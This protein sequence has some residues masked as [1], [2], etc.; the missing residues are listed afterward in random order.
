VEKKKYNECKLWSKEERKIR[1]ICSLQEI[2]SLP[3]RLLHVIRVMA[4]ALFVSFLASIILA[5]LVIP[6]AS[7]VPPRCTFLTA[8]QVLSPLFA[9]PTNPFTRQAMMIQIPTPTDPR[10]SFISCSVKMRLER[11]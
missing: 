9:L 11:I 5:V 1:Y 6:V 3:R 2:P 7:F 4:L 10:F 8:N